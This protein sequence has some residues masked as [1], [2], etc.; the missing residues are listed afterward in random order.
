MSASITSLL[1]SSTQTDP[2]VE[3]EK[4]VEVALDDLVAAGALQTRNRMDIESL[5]DPDGESNILT[6][7]SEN[8]AVIDARAARESS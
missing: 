3:A 4:Q 7:S 6:V 2:V 1:N 8:Q 5:L